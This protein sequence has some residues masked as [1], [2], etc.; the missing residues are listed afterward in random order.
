MR[1]T[2]ILLALLITAVLATTASAQ[3][4]VW[5]DVHGNST[6]GSW[7]R[8]TKDRKGDAAND[9]VILRVGG[10]TVGLKFWELMPEDQKF[11]KELLA[12][13]GKDGDHLE[14]TDE[15]RDWTS[16]T[17]QKGR[18]Q[19][20]KVEKDG[21]ISV[22]VQSEKK[23]FKFEE[24]VVEDQDYLRAL[25]AK[26]GKEDLVPAKPEGEAATTPAVT[27]NNSPP[28]GTPAT[29]VPGFPNV[30]GIPG[31]TPPGIPQPGIPQPGF[32]TQGPGGTGIPGGNTAQPGFPPTPNPGFNPGATGTTPGFN[33]P[34][35]GLPDTSTSN[36][37]DVTI[38]NHQTGLTSNPPSPNMGQLDQPVFTP[39]VMN[40]PEINMP[41][42]QEI[43]ECSNCG[44]E[45]SESATT[46]PHC[47]IRFDYV[48]N[49]DGSRTNLPGGRAGGIGAAVFVIMALG[50]GA[51]KFFRRT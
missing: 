23:S 42:M 17:G 21:S 5:H 34:G 45:V 27:G 12:E 7:Q 1:G 8:F 9:R 33:Q 6:A 25:L 20:L 44:K 39:P 18:G 14:I 50:G 32:G 16:R 46:C 26:D 35:S 36:I 19:F 47:R 4:R 3:S 30:P 51:L 28:A 43:Y 38:P 22:I 48:E 40:T 11:V 49:S 37:P 41:Q 29:G 31:V 2:R 24:F 13:S 10:K 15:P